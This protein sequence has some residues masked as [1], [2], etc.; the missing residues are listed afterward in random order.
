MSENKIIKT[1]IQ[2]IQA[3]ELLMHFETLK[4][5]IDNLQHTIKGNPETILLTRKQ[6]SEFFEVSLVTIHSWCNKGLIPSYRIGNKVRFK[7]SEVLDALKTIQKRK[8]NS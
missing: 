1:E 3:H 2:S 8:S 7:K 5:C 4:D 6:V